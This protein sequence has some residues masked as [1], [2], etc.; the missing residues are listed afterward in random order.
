[1]GSTNVYRVLGVK[2]GVIVQ[3]LDILKG[4]IPTLIL[5]DALQI[6]SEVNP[7]IIKIIAGLSSV[8]GHIFSPFVGFKGGKGINTAVGMM[9]GISPIDLGVC[10]IFFLGAIFTSGMIS[11]GALLG[12]TVLPIS[13]LIR[14]E[15]V[16]EVPGFEYLLIFFSFMAILIFYTHRTNIKRLRKGEENKFERLQILKFK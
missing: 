14:N 3:I 9:I 11:V 13:L 6:E 7:I 1:M 15:F 5:T 10:L 12:A 2:W 16:S 8:L 4:L